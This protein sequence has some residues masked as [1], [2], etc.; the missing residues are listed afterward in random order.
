MHIFL[1]IKTY[2]SKYLDSVLSIRNNWILLSRIFRGWLLLFYFFGVF[3]FSS[4]SAVDQIS[5]GKIGCYIAE[6]WKVFRPLWNFRE[7]V[8]W[9]RNILDL[10]YPVQFDRI[11]EELVKIHTILDH[12]ID[13]RLR[14]DLDR[15][16]K[17]LSKMLAIRYPFVVKN[18]FP[19]PTFDI[20]DTLHFSLQKYSLSCEISAASMI[21]HQLSNP[22]TEDTF[23]G[24]IKFSGNDVM[25]GGMWGNPDT[26]FVGS[27]TWS[28][29]KHTGYGVYEFPVAEVMKTLG[30]HTEII[31]ESQYNDRG[32]T[33]VSHLSILLSHLEKWHMVELWGDWC[34]DELYDD[35]V[36]PEIDMRLIEQYHFSGKNYCDTTYENRNISWMTAEGI[37]VDGLVGEHAFILLGYIRVLPHPSHIIV[38]DTDTWRHIYPINEWMRKWKLL[39]YRSLIVQK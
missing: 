8:N 33:P 1:T 4:L 23:I 30:L 6:K 17:Y 29:R 35:G 10:P 32:L 14:Q 9:Y 11:S 25:D 38:G 27:I 36:V 13:D 31:N 37:R 19:L 26:W 20:T 21:I 12:N 18:Q 22:M 15:N 7:S 5:C 2:I 24:K 34:T 28:Q 3:S 16:E 39:N